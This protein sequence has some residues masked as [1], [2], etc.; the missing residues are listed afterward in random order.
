MTTSIQVFALVVQGMLALSA[1]SGERPNPNGDAAVEISVDATST[2]TPLEHIWAFHGYDE[3]NYTTTPEGKSLLQRIVAA[4][5][6]PVHVRTHFLLNTGDGA[7]AMKWGSTNVYTE[8]DTG[9]PIY[10][11]TITDAIHDT[12]LGT[13]AF[14]FVELGFMPQALSIRPSPYR[15]TSTISLDGGCFYPPSDYS[16]WG[17]L[18]GSWAKHAR[19][20]YAEVAENW[21]WE[22]WNEPDSAY[23]R[24]SFTE[25]AQLYDYTEAALHSVIPDAPLGGPAVIDAG[26]PFLTKFLEHCANGLNAATGKTGT[27]LDLVT[28]HA[29]GGAALNGAHVE[30][31][32]GNQLRQHR[33]GFQAVAAFPAFE[34]TPIYITEADPDGC[35]AC[36]TD[37][38]PAA[39]YRLSTAYGAYELAMMK[40]TLEL[41]EETGVNLAGVLTWAFTF[42]GT[43]YFAGYRALSTN[44]IDLPVFGALGLLGSL[45]G[46]HVPLSSSG[47][48]DLP[49]VL[50]HGVHAAPDIDG[51]ATIDVRTIQVLVWNYHD[52]IVDAG[53]APVHLAVK[54]P[55]DFGERARIAHSRVDELH[56]DAYA[57]WRSQGMPAEP[58][59]AQIAELR[60]AMTP[61]PLM[62]DRFAVPDSEHLIH[63]DF[64][65]PRFAVSLVTV[66][67]E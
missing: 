54:V 28:F 49:D 1:C 64:E 29:K 12:L 61:V 30:L 50:A 60:A 24:G 40:R 37:L 53:S 3:I 58:S 4:H 11:W 18:V 63:L 14:P 57:A 46:H 13:G 31:D 66:S 39:S 59:A 65:L 26:G 33:A 36:S 47:A 42:P 7:P 52:E 35:A 44:G 32:L 23:F 8:T 16:K 41:A 34:R 9:E 62:P 2:G 15:N 67:P 17:D 27:R 45:R 19:D 48:R 51:V 21:L 6:A 56:G 25:Y 43:P 5:S 55:L 22:L 38:L 20:R 10:D